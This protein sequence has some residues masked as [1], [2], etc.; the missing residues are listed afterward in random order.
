MFG[1]EALSPPVCP[2]ALRPVDLPSGRIQEDRARPRGHPFRLAAG[3]F[4]NNRL[5]LAGQW[6]ADVNVHPQPPLFAWPSHAR[7]VD[8]LSPKSQLLTWLCGHKNGYDT[9][10]EKH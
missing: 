6:D 10:V 4:H 2:F 7:I 1:T 8:N 9:P 3:R 5:L